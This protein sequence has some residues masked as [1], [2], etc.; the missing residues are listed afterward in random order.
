MFKKVLYV[1]TVLLVGFLLIMNTVLSNIVSEGK[2]MIEESLADGDYIDAISFYGTWFDTDAA[3]ILNDSDGQILHVYN[4]IADKYIYEYVEGTEGTD[5]EEVENSYIIKDNALNFM[6]FDVGSEF[7]TSN[8]DEEAID[9]GYVTL[10]FIDGTTYSIALDNEVGSS[11]DYYSYYS[12]IPITIY[13]STVLESLTELDGSLTEVPA[14][15]SI[16]ITDYDGTIHITSELT[17]TD[18]FSFESDIKSDFADIIYEYNQI[19]TGELEL[20]DDETDE[21]EAELEDKVTVLLEEKE[22]GIPKDISVVFGRSGFLIPTGLVL[23]SYII[24]V[25]ILGYFVFRKKKENFTPV[26]RTTPVV[27]PV[28]VIEESSSKEE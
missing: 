12:Y 15:A 17:D 4:A 26:K 11:Y 7:A 21:A 25:V 14:I 19:I 13:E 22:Y 24:I 28:D 20:T 18:Q 9:L 10:T 8:D 1:F 2:V 27:K 16:K 23:G 3:Y 6:L 5:E